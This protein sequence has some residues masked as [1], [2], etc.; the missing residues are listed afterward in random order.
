MRWS[1]AGELR[2]PRSNV[3]YP[4]I[5]GRPLTP[6]SREPDEPVGQPRIP[7]RDPLELAGAQQCW[8][9]LQLEDAER[10]RETQ[11]LAALVGAA[12]NAVCVRCGQ[13][14]PDCRDEAYLV[15]VRRFLGSVWS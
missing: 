5:H 6:D 4:G 11:I 15:R 1:Y 8:V 13:E 2:V 9:C 3:R 10:A 14:A 12:A 7:R